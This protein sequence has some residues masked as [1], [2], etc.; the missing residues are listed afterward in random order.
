MR[1]I[2]ISIVLVALS[3]FAGAATIH[4]PA[5]Q[6][7]IQAGINVAV[8][9]DTVL[10]AEGTYTG[11]GNRDLSFLG[12]NICLLSVGGP[13]VTIIDCEA[14]VGDEHRAV[15]L[16]NGEDSTSI[17]DGFTITGAYTTGFS[18]ALFFLHASATVKNCIVTDN[19]ISGI[20]YTNYSTTGVVED[21]IIS[22]N[23]GS[24]IGYGGPNLIVSNCQIIN[25][26]G[27]GVRSMEHIR[28]SN[29]LVANNTDDGILSAGSM[30]AQVIL[31]NCTFYG[32]RNGLFYESTPPKSGATASAINNI[33][34][35]TNCI[36]SSN[37][38]Y[39]VKLFQW[40]GPGLSCCNS[41]DNLLGDYDI[42]EF[43]TLDTTDCISLD[44]L[45]CDQENGDFRIKD[46]SPCAP[47]NNSCGGSLIGA[48]GVGCLCCQTRGD[49]DG[50]SF[51][52]SPIDVSDVTFLVA[53]LF[54]GGQQPPCD[55][56]A[57]VDNIIGPGGSIDTSDLTYLVAYLFK[58]GPQPPPCG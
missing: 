50:L 53:F 51:S 29:C 40:G 19:L 4:V 27:S 47:F 36:F 2:I 17:I 52:G 30:I 14:G 54:K 38:E 10:V 57:D 43:Y 35:I 5:D 56:A 31:T 1:Q 44:P 32:N 46:N 48:F 3:G 23:D 39:G 34:W 33:P 28:M 24:G 25:N 11:L 58:G 41:F 45:Y 15:Y 9:G 12:N 13:D 42:V 21:C 55:D 37:R 18:A 22:Y 7:T 26:N 8:E 20:S 6:P 16:D 49:V